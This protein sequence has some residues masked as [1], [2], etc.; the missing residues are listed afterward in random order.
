[1]FYRGTSVL[2]RQEHRLAA[3]FEAITGGESRV[4]SRFFDG[5]RRS[6]DGGSI[7]S[8]STA[9]YQDLSG[10]GEDDPGRRQG[11]ACDAACA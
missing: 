4:R 8:A 3:T 11:I 6:D 2:Q 9:A 10:F 7:G 1:M 5:S